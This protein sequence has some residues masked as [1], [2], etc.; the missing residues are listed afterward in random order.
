M[1]GS[2]LVELPLWAQHS[3]VDFVLDFKSKDPGA[4]A[5][6]TLEATYY[7][8]KLRT[9]YDYGT[10]YGNVRMKAIRGLVQFRGAKGCQG[11]GEAA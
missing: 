5:S 9:K 11:E 8:K 6:S 3:S 10:H 7:G 4:K 1:P 2:V